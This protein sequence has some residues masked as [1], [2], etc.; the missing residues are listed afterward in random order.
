MLL[1]HNVVL[2]DQH[3]LVSYPITGP[4]QRVRPSDGDGVED[5]KQRLWVFIELARQ[6]DGL[7]TAVLSTSFDGQLWHPVLT[8]AT[9]RSARIVDLLSLTAFAPLLRVE[10]TGGDVLPPHQLSVR[11]ASDGPFTV[12]PG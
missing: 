7:V 4:E 9:R 11:L 5:G 8:L 3:D 6:G 1:R 12:V 10:T 2:L